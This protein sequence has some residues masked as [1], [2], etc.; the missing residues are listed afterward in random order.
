MRE[1]M[2]AP[3]PILSYDK[4]IELDYLER[5]K[6]RLIGALEEPEIIDTLGALALRLCDTA[7][8][9]EPM[10]YVEGE[11]L[12]DS[13]PDLDWTDKN[14]IPLICSNK[15]VVSGRQIS[16]MPVQKDRIEKTLV[17]DMRVFLDDM[18][19]YLEEDYPPT[20]IERTDAGVDG[21]LLY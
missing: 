20:K 8:M 10:E 14:I 13:H 17:G 15:F 12:G 19:R 2:Q 21:F 6:D 18:Y 4:P 3:Q 11:E 9:L 5:M 7:Q 1:I 16:P